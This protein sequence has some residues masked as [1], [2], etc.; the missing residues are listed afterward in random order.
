MDSLLSAIVLVGWREYLPVEVRCAL[1]A[2]A[3]KYINQECA[4]KVTFVH[5]K[6]SGTIQRIDMERFHGIVGTAFV[7]DLDDGSGEATF[8]I[9][10]DAESEFPD[11]LQI[12]IKKGKASRRAGGVPRTPSGEIL[13]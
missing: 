5:P 8:L 7:A 1:V 13:H 6:C 10:R 2:V 3:C 9:V 4:G 12:V 11:D